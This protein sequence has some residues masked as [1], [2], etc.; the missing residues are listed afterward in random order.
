MK[1]FLAILVSLVLC[2]SLLGFSNIY[3]EESNSQYIRVGLLQRFHQQESINIANTSIVVGFDLDGEITALATRTN[4]NGFVVR[5]LNSQI[6][7]K[8]NGTPLF[9][10]DENIIPIIWDTNGAP[11]SLSS[12]SYRGMIEF[13]QRNNR[14]NAINIVDMEEYLYSVVSS[15]MPSS[16]H[17]EALK[18]QAVAAR[19]YTYTRIKMNIEAGLNFDLCDT[20]MSQVYNGFEQETENSR[21]AVNSTRGLMIYFNNEVINATYFSSSGGVTENAENVWQEA[22]PYFRSVIDTFETEGRVWQ[23]T[24]TFSEIQSILNARNINIGTVQSLSINRNSTNR[25]GLLIIEGSN[26]NHILRQENIRTFFA[27]T[28]GGSLMSRNFTIT[29]LN[30]SSVT[31]SGRGF[32][33]GVG[34]SQF[35]AKGMAEAGFTFDQIL[36]HYYTG[37]TIR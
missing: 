32:G 5:I 31:F 28:Q 13:S 22:R 33:H 15:E 2:F 27:G 4:E 26:G 11:V 29:N 37:T 14:I 7:I 18:A 10:F 20:T 36:I 3:A 12:R 23:R 16:W 6:V 30:G 35:G 24:I 9:A 25:V 8:A 1:K 19:S 34:M 21:Y 17:M